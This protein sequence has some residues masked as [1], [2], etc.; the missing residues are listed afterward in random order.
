MPKQ[1][2]ELTPPYKSTDLDQTRARIARSQRAAKRSLR[3]EL[4]GQNSNQETQDQE[5]PKH[6][7]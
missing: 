2:L 7:L 5:T 4:E 3:T 1:K 6:E